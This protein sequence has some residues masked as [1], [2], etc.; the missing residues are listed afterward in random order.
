MPSRSCDAGTDVDSI[1]DAFQQSDNRIDGRERGVG[2]G[3]TIVKEFITACG[4]SSSVSSDGIGTGT[5]MVVRLPA[6]LVSPA[7]V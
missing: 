3:S 1:F 4:G 6:G 7:G 5:T 2:I